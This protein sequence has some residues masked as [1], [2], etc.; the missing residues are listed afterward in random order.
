MKRDDIENETDADREILRRWA[1]DSSHIDVGDNFD[2]AVRAKLADAKK[3]APFPHRRRHLRWV[4][5]AIA[6]AAAVGAFLITRPL[7][8]PHDTAP[9]RTPSAPLATIDDDALGAFGEDIEGG[10]GEDSEFAALSDSTT[11]RETEQAFERIFSSEELAFIDARGDDALGD[12][13]A[14]EI[15]EMNDE[16]AR[17]LEGSIDA[18]RKTKSG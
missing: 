14:D 2:A 18:A 9:A 6:A 11:D 17:G 8:E 5:P 7:D 3:R 4:I 13:I 10:L 12:E 16:A 1:A 15:S